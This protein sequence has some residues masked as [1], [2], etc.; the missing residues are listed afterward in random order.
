MR[1]LAVL[2]MT[3]ISL[4][5]AATAS[6]LEDGLAS[7][8]AAPLRGDPM[9]MGRSQ[10]AA[11]TGQ[12]VDVP[13]LGSGDCAQLA[14]HMPDITDHGV[15]GEDTLEPVPNTL[16]APG[17]R[18]VQICY[19]EFGTGDQKGCSG[20]M[21]ARNIVLTAG[22]C[23]YLHGGWHRGITVYPGRAGMAMAPFGFCHAV[24][25]YTLRGWQSNTLREYD[26]GAIK[27]DCNVGDRTGWFAMSGSGVQ[28]GQRT[29]AY[30]YPC[31]T[32][33][34]LA[35]NP[36]RQWT[37][38]DRVRNVSNTNVFYRNDTYPCMSGSPVF[39]GDDY[40]TVR[41]VHARG[42]GSCQEESEGGG[43]NNIGTKL[44]TER[45]ANLLAWMR[46]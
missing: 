33:G 42:C 7:D 22:H 18:V 2:A 36:Y 24:S 4:I 8:S 39:I 16:A 9:T 11:G 19:T 21:V 46:Q 29:I 44:T 5:G 34:K 23:V 35:S 10:F 32:A 20:A 12:V 30:G 25:M 31:G 15:F 27:L 43:D 45:V 37:S 6:G 17:R 38:E 14:K 40:A 28:M 1:Q 26:I 3:A 41:A 13:E